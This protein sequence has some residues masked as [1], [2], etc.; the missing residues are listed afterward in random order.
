MG[1]A[2]AEPPFCADF[3]SVPITMLAVPFWAFCAPTG[4]AGAA[5]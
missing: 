3:G 2:R 5:G 1:M 4:R